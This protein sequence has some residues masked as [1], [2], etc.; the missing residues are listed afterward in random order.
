MLGNKVIDHEI[1]RGVREQPFEV[2]VVYKVVDSLIQTL[3]Q[4]P[5][6]WRG[7]S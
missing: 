5:A 4:L 1:I 3:W 6:E 2:A 7:P